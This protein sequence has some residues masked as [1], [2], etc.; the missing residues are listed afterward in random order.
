MDFIDLLD[1]RDEYW[2]TGYYYPKRPQNA[3]DGKAEFKYRHM[4]PYSRV[5]DKVLEQI[6]LDNET[7]TIK[8]EDDCNF[9]NKGYISTQDGE[10]WQIREIIHNEQTRGSEEALRLFKVSPHAEYD[11]LLVRVFNPWEIAE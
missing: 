7:C 11:M 10:F 9:K 2:F 3:E 4:S 1:P 5:F 8:T 6:R